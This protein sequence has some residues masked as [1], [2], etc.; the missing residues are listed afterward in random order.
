MVLCE[1]QQVYWSAGDWETLRPWLDRVSLP[2]LSKLTGIPERTLRSYRLGKRLPPPATR[3]AITRALA[4]M[5]PITRS[6]SS[7]GSPRTSP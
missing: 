1:S 5:L 6:V 2:E 4:T 3:E 7:G